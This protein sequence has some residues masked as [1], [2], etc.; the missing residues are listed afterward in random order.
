MNQ[1]KV[2]DPNQNR[3][4]NSGPASASRGEEWAGPAWARQRGNGGQQ[5]D[6]SEDRQRYME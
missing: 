2:N 3:S 5:K 6:T 1:R 4:G